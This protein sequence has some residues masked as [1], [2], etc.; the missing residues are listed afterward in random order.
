M[1]SVI[2]SEKSPTPALVTAW[3]CERGRGRESVSISG[4]LASS[5]YCT[6][7]HHNQ[8]FIQ[9]GGLEFPPSHNSPLP[10]KN[11]QIVHGFNC[12]TINISYL[13]IVMLI[14]HLTWHKYVSSKCCLE[15]LS[16]IASEAIW[17]DLKFS[18]PPDSPSKHTCLCTCECA[19]TRYYH[20]A[21]ILFPP[22]PP[23]NSKS[24]I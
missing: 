4:L 17:E 8:G 7:L 9:E 14:L 12:G 16:Q 24:C 10:Q 5:S 15:G 6:H 2:C 21:T 19:F 1:L 20:L 11:L 18:L 23:P 22:P 3:I 13:I